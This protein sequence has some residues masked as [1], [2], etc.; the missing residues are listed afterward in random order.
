MKKFGFWSAKFGLDV[1]QYG[2]KWEHRNDLHGLHL[3]TASLNTEPF[4]RV[5][6]LDQSNLP[7]GYIVCKLQSYFV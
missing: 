6:D 2:E 5:E 3:H 7:A 1:V 4:V